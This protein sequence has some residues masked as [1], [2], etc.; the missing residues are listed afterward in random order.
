MRLNLPQVRRSLV[1]GFTLIELLVVTSIIAALAVTVFAALNPPQRIK[2]ANDSRRRSDVDSILIAI[3]QYI[4]DNDGSLPT[5][6]STGMVETQIGSDTSGCEIST[7]G[8]AA[9]AAACVNLTTPLTAYLKTVPVDPVSGS[10][11]RSGYTVEVDTNN[12]VT[13]RAC[14]A[15]AASSI[16][17]SR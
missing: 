3:H 14:G 5:G 16:S 8:C 15:Q 4:V 13:I 9:A 11:T 1:A 2:E 7:A 17:S 12:I 10:A 6:L